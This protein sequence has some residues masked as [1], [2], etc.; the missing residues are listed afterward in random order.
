MGEEGKLGHIRKE[1]DVEKIKD[2]ESHFRNGEDST[3]HICFLH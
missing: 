3:F 1:K 2:V